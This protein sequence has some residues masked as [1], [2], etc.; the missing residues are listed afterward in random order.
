M[1]GIVIIS[2]LAAFVLFC[3]AARP[4]QAAAQGMEDTPVSIDNI[5]RGVQNG[6]YTCVLVRVD[7]IPAVHLTGK[8]ADG[9]TY[10]DV[11]PITQEDW[12]TL[13]AEGYQVEV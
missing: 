9:K 12:N 13:K 11:Y 2:A 3:V 10:S 8:T 6:W 7:G 1:D 4:S 5:R